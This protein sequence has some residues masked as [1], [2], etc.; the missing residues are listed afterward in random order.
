MTEPQVSP[1]SDG[2]LPRRRAKPAIPGA[3]P[4]DV[5]IRKSSS[6]TSGIL[7]IIGGIALIGFALI[8]FVICLIVRVNQFTLQ[9]LTTLPTL[10]GIGTIM[11]GWTSIRSPSE[12][13]VDQ[14]GITLAG[15]P[16]GRTISWDEV[17]LASA[18]D[19]PLAHKRRLTLFDK[20]GKSL[21][22]ISNDFDDF[23]KLVDQVRGYVA[24]QPEN[25]SGS[26][27]LSKARRMSLL[28]GFFGIFLGVAAVFI[29]YDT[30]QTKRGQELLATSGVEGE[31]KV[32]RRFLAPNG[33]TRRIE[34]EVAGADGRTASHNVEV[35]RTYWDELEGA[36]TVPIRYVPAEPQFSYLLTGEIEEDKHGPIGGYGLSAGGAVL[37]LFMLGVSIMQFCGWDFGTDP[38]T[39]KLGFRKIGT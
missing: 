31:G 11:R 25:V 6:N 21:A 26:L 13:I 30:W 33:V 10:L 34:Y 8:G 29:A 35:E 28:T 36:A 14:D 2:S 24:S 16:G 38:K 18:T 9:C 37:S 22:T 19:A 5:Y 7:L 15:G 17:G 32:L 23:E 12:V 20:R 3:P 27:Q 4:A 39:K 1:H